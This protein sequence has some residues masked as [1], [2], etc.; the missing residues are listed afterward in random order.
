MHLA[1][2]L[3]EDAVAFQS[4]NRDSSDESGAIGSTPLPFPRL[5]Y[6]SGNSVSPMIRATTHPIKTQTPSSTTVHRGELL[7]CIIGM[8][9]FIVLLLSTW[10]LRSNPGV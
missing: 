2:N 3:A 5:L 9:V 6:L 1:E 7:S 10:D 4:P 8:S